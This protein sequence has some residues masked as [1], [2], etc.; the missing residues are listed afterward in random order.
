MA[1][2]IERSEIREGQH[3]AGKCP[4]WRHPGQGEGRGGKA[5]G[6][7]QARGQDRRE[8]DPDPSRSALR[9]E[10]RLLQEAV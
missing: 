5:A 8:H 6:H 3:G 4:G 1:E 10:F 9:L 7:Q 2:P